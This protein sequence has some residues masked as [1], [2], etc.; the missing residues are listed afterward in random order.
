MNAQA[1]KGRIEV[2]VDE[3]VEALGRIEHIVVL[4]QENRSF[5]QML[6]Y[7]RLS[8]RRPALEGLEGGMANLYEDQ[9]G[10]CPQYRGL[11]FAVKE[12]RQR[13]MTTAQGPLH[14]GAAV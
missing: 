12:L 14:D 10:K 8:G 6:G 5:D 1:K 9:T 11:S 4:M 7:L 2:E 13:R 3:A